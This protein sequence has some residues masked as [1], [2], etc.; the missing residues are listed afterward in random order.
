MKRN[1]N[2]SL[3]KLKKNKPPPVIIERYETYYP[4]SDDWAP[5]F[6]R[7]TVRIAVMLWSSL[8]LVRVCI[9]G[10]DDVGMEKDIVVLPSSA[11]SIFEQQILFVNNN[12]PNPL[13]KEWLLDN[14]FKRA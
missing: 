3:R 7:N 10:A 4:T 8:T 5:N 9:W 12:L 11:N 14:G 2:K 6:P 13:T 1:K